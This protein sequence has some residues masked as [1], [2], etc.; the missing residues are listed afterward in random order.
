[1]KGI[2]KRDNDKWF[3]HYMDWAYK[4]TSIVGSLGNYRKI[5]EEFVIELDPSD[6]KDVETYYKTKQNLEN[7]EVKFYTRFL[8]GKRYAK[9]KK[10][11]EGYELDEIAQEVLNDTFNNSIKF[12]PT[13]QSRIAKE[14]S[15]KCIICG[16]DIEITKTKE[17]CDDCFDALKSLILEKKV[18]NKYK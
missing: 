16:G 17:L 5:L 2:L 6:S 15:Y 10:N 11:S 12:T 1:M 13:I 18:K 8:S 3:I 7:K 4:T 9:L 14:I